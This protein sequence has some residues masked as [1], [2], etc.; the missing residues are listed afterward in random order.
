MKP[1]QDL[2]ILFVGSTGSNGIDKVRALEELGVDVFPLDT[3][4][5]E[6]R[7]PR[8]Q[9]SIAYRFNLGPPVRAFNRQLLE[10]A[11]EN[12]PFTHV[13]FDKGRWVWPETL[14]SLKASL[15]A[16]LVHY[17][18]DCLFY[19][20][21]S[22]H[23]VACL[24]IFDYL[25]TTKSFE[26]DH[27]RRAGAGQV[28]HVW[29]GVSAERFQ[30][31]QPTP[32]QLAR[33]RSDVSF[34]GRCEPHYAATLREASRCGGELRIWGPRWERYARMHRWAVPHVAGPAVWF[35]EY[36]AALS[37]AKIC[38]GLLSKRFPES[39]TTRSFEIPA[40]GTFMLAER[41]DDHL[42]LFSE[43]REAEFFDGPDEMLDKLRYYLSHD[44]ERER[45][46]AAGR[47][48]WLTSDYSRKARFQEMLEICTGRNVT[49]A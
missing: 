2:R 21:T 30:P 15:G 35:D 12:A 9:R 33:Y 8:V 16:T 24:G 13:F 23:F 28:H 27:Y 36:R 39:V 38:L 18:N 45:I 29:D 46:A 1:F 17:S 10:T 6:D 31:G 26:I 43:G 48:R 11:A 44:E 34:L 22:R 47:E 20:N 41:T 4:A 14:R 3:R 37:S 40:V 7:G 42:T 19:D 25:F 32:E 5:F 49:P